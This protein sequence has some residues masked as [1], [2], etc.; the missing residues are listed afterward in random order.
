MPVSSL[1]PNKFAPSTWVQMTPSGPCRSALKQPCFLHSSDGFCCI[2]QLCCEAELLQEVLRTL[3]G[4]HFHN[5]SAWYCIEQRMLA[6]SFFGRVNS[7]R[8]HASLL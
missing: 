4:K 5:S 3:T 7:P 1:L 6:L 2:K 8:L